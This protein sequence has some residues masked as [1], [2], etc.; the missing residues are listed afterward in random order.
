M[1]ILCISYVVTYITV[2]V[3]LCFNMYVLYHMNSR[4]KWVLR[5]LP[6]QHHVLCVCISVV[7]GYIFCKNNCSDFSTN[8]L[9]SLNLAFIN[10]T[11]MT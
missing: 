7:L 10:D 1:H 6:R 3:Y 2:C 8:V 9:Q 5:R 11:Q 4:I